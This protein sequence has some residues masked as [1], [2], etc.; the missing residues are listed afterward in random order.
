MQ[1]QAAAA[2][3]TTSPSGP[4]GLQP[5][6]GSIAEPA[7]ERIKLEADAVKVEQAASLEPPAI[8]LQEQ[9]DVELAGDF[10]T[11]PAVAQV[12]CRLCICINHLS[13]V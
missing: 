8:K 10:S 4:G 9:I 11:A 12:H 7:S 1:S 2:L 6:P 13:V 5:D 3:P